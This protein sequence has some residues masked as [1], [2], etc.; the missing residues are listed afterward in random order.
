MIVPLPHVLPFILHFKNG[1]KDLYSWWTVWC[2]VH[3]DNIPRGESRQ[4]NWVGV[5][6]LETARQ[7]P[8]MERRHFVFISGLKCHP[9]HLPAKI[10]VGVKWRHPFR[11]PLHNQQSTV[12]LPNN[13]TN[14][15]P[16]RKFINKFLRHRL[17]FYWLNSWTAKLYNLDRCALTRQLGITI[18]S[19]HNNVGLY[20]STMEFF[21]FLQTWTRRRWRVVSSNC[22]PTQ[23][24]LNVNNK[25]MTPTTV[26][27]MR[28]DLSL[29]KRKKVQ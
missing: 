25:Y 3:R 16:S 12:Y 29:W 27:G 5:D 23:E 4:R 21:A 20:G 11:I 6:R 1:T 24:N 9:I 22:Q 19:S 13:K 10:F 17:R 8:W 28:N 14:V 2:V 7:I 26:H 15:M 18:K